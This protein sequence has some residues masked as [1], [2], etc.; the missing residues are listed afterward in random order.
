MTELEN[1]MESL[2]KIFHRYADEDG[3]AT[4]LTKKELKKLM[5]AELPTFL[6]T[7]KNPKAVDS[8]LK[9][10]DQNKDDKL[11]FEEFLP[12]VVGL[13]MACEKCYMLH[14]KKTGKK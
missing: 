7:Q 12:L 5:E 11:D 13:S 8:I 9:D 3:D 14:N 6:K 2:I 1:C 4:T 10:L